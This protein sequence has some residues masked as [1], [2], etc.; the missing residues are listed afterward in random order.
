M[1]A[2]PDELATDNCKA[3]RRRSERALLLPSAI[4]ITRRSMGIPTCPS[5]V[6]WLLPLPSQKLGQNV[7]QGGQVC[8]IAAAA[9]MQSNHLL[10]E[11]LHFIAI[12]LQ[13]QHQP[14]DVGASRDADALSLVSRL[15]S[16]T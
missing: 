14:A 4:S 5:L 16:D 3:L 10:D 2:A 1:P 6:G 15:D 13:E 8:R 11:L 7:T 12:P 9:R